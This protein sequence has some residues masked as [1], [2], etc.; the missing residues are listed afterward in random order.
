MVG[1]KWSR[2]APRE[3]CQ[4]M[5]SVVNWRYSKKYRIKVG[6]SV[7]QSV[8]RSVGRS[9][10]VDCR[11]RIERS[12]WWN[13]SRFFC[14][15]AKSEQTESNLLLQFCFCLIRT[16]TQHPAPPRSLTHLCE[17]DSI[18]TEPHGRSESYGVCLVLTQTVSYQPETEP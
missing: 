4:E 2:P 17:N 3:K 16:V 18:N 12:C 6:R 13:G 8:S 9:V 11:G 14:G 5:T 15:L 7:G 1:G 10:I